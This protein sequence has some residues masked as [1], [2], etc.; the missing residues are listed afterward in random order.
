MRDILTQVGHFSFDGVGH[1]TIDDNSSLPGLV[2]GSK[3]RHTTSRRL[4]IFRMRSAKEN[5][6]P[7]ATSRLNFFL[8][9]FGDPIN[10]DISLLL[11]GEAIRCSFCKF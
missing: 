4:S 1:F 5:S 2:G 3:I 8:K 7:V 11:T 6:L 9:L 10:E